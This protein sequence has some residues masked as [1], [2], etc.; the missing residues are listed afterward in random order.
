M[1]TMN[2][3]LRKFYTAIQGEPIKTAAIAMAIED[4]IGDLVRERYQ[5]FEDDDDVR[6]EAEQALEAIWEHIETEDDGVCDLPIYAEVKA[7]VCLSDVQENVIEDWHDSMAYNRDPYAYYG[8]SR[9][10]F[11]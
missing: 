3:H 2:E 11:L 5:D 1:T 7:R 9:D 4:A 8:V 6:R 10:D